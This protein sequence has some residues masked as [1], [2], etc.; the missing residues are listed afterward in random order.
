MPSIDLLL[1]IEEFPGAY[2]ILY[3]ESEDNLKKLLENKDRITKRLAKKDQKPF[4][5][6]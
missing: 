1:I 5:S 2:E 3:L 6:F 4:E